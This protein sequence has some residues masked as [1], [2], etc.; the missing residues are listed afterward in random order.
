MTVVSVFFYWNHCIH[1]FVLYV[2]SGIAFISQIHKHR[3]RYADKT[4]DQASTLICA[5]TQVINLND[6]LNKVLKLKKTLSQV[7]RRF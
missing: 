2:I 7:L 4:L 5:C 6:I 1:L 3:K